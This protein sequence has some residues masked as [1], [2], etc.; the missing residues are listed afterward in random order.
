[1][2]INSTFHAALRCT[3]TAVLLCLVP[4]PSAAATGDAPSLWIHD[5]F[6][7][8]PGTDDP[9]QL[10]DVRIEAGRIAEIRPESAAEPSPDGTNDLPIL[11]AQGRFLLP[12]FVD[13][14][15]HV[16]LGPVGFDMVDGVPHMKMAP[17]PEVPRRSLAA[18]LAHG[19]TTVRD[20]GGPTQTLLSLRQRLES[21]EMNGPRLRVAGAVIDR[22]ELEGLTATVEGPEAVRAEVRRQA[23]AGVDWIKL[24]TQLDQDELKAGIDEA[25]AHG[26]PAVAHLQQ[27]SWT[28][29]AE[30]GL[31]ALVHVVPGSP[32]LLPESTRDAYM[33]DLLGT[34]FLYSW[35]EHAD[36][37]SQEIQH[38]LQTL[39]DTEVTLDLT[40]VAF[41]GM[42]RGD[43][44]WR[45]RQL[46][47]LRW[48]TDSLVENW[49][50]LFTFNVGWVP[51]DFPRARKAWSKTLEFSRLLHEAGVHLTV[52]TD[53]NNPWT[54]PGT[55][56]HRELE[57]LAEAGIPPRAI[58][59][60]ATT[61]GVRSP[62]TGARD[63]RSASWP[64]RRPGAAGAQSP[65]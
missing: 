35:F 24:Y 17:D 12:G 28:E 51:E 38:M 4:L 11:D 39:V 41:E 29:A 10:A 53:A 5:A 34:R 25:H 54:V 65:R 46:P 22:Q 62:G 8:D 15:A 6:L 27:I 52:G 59:R 60:M 14:H 56:F 23:Q 32:H 18:L 20:P 16:A 57:L 37:Q 61:H 1:M 2:P 40:L 63:R 26:L 45:T 43:Q 50:G 64:C 49:R 3:C 48:A 7:I 19:V 44:P 13:T 36:F 47:E 33:A 30:L 21:G 58:L 42:V 55:S 9:P 31:D